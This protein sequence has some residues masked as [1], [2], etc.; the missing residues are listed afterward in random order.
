MLTIIYNS[1]SVRKRARRLRSRPGQTTDRGLVTRCLAKRPTKLYSPAVPTI[2][3]SSAAGP[4]ATSISSSMP[5]VERTFRTL[6]GVVE[7]GGRG[8]VACSGSRCSTRR[9]PAAPATSASSPTASARWRLPASRSWTTAPCERSCYVCLR[10]YGNQQE[11]DLLDRH[12]AADFFRRFVN[13]PTVEEHEYPPSPYV[14]TSLTQDSRS[15]MSVWGL[16][17]FRS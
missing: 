1:P 16:S 7:A 10:S 5:N 2:S 13:A 4:S 9:Y 14:S 17:R 3:A 15:Y 6:C 11:A 12:V 8:S